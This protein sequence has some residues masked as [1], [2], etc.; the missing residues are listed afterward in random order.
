MRKKPN[1][2]TLI[3]VMIVVAVIAIL[4]MIA[5]PIYQRYVERSRESATQT[6]LQQLMLAEMALNAGDEHEFI[7]IN[8][9]N[10]TTDLPAIQKLM[11]FGFRPDPRVGF[12]VL[13]LTGPGGAPMGIIAYAAYAA[14]GSRMF[15]Y[16]TVIRQGAQVVPE[17]VAPADF[18][19]SYKTEL[20]LFRMDS[21]SGGLTAGGRLGMSGNLVN[22]IRP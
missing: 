4:A 21:G 20:Y 9:Q 5:V 10:A 13:E 11:D 1:G 19:A 18:P 6:L 2:F 7:L 17:T 15:V 22:E 12:A 14:P 3:E 16:D 8:G